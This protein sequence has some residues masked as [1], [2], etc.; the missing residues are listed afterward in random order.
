MSLVTQLA[1]CYDRSRGYFA[2][3]PR[4]FLMSVFARFTSVR[5]LVV[6]LHRPKASPS[7]PHSGPTMVEPLDID[8][9]VLK[10][11]HDGVCDDLRLSRHALDELLSFCST[12]PCY[13]D[14][15]SDCAFV[16][17]V[18]G[19]AAHAA[20]PYR[21]GIYH[22]VLRSSPQLRTLA[23][24]TQLLAIARQYLGTEPVLLGADIWWNFSGP[25]DGEQQRQA[26][27]AF[28]Y[29]ID[30]YA[31]LAFFFYLTDV[32][33][34]QGP[35]LYIRG[36]HAKKRWQD[37]FTLF[38]RRTD[39]EMERRYGPERQVLLCGPAGYGFAEDIFGF[40]K[41][42]HPEHGDRLIL[43]LR[44]GLHDYDTTSPS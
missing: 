27:Q 14:G 5:T 40:H 9:A 44:Y 4:Y 10:I 22:H 30:G 34:Q 8:D 23:S 29:D 19:T 42:V 12:A 35:H 38:K 21:R 18:N 32:G 43:R 15:K 41:A 16:Y 24:D 39:A 31:G 25:A 2:R 26:G 6:R 37:T 33:P 11:R 36:T 3:G 1:L 28:H 7:D 17:G 13:G 20:R